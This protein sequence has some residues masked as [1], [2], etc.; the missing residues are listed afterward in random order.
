MGKGIH[1]LGFADQAL[2]VTWKSETRQG[3]NP[4]KVPYAYTGLP[5]SSTDARTWTTRAIAKHAAELGSHDGIGIM[6]ARIDEGRHLGGVDLDSCIDDDGN[7]TVWAQEIV[8]LLNSYTEVS[9]SNHGLKVFFTHDPRVTLVEG[10]HWRSAV[11]AS[12]RSTRT[13]SRRPPAPPPA[14][15]WR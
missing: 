1:L 6:L 13:S 12:R 15:C 10:V 14:T 5:A 2:W 3:R 9:P 4:T 7:L 8:E 11:R